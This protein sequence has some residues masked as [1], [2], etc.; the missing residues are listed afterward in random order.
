MSISKELEAEID[1][2]INDNREGSEAQEENV[3]VQEQGEAQEEAQ[4][5]VQ[6]ETQEEEA[7]EEIQEDTQKEI[8]EDT[9]A[10][11]E[12]EEDTP[13][14]TKG[15]TPEAFSDASLTRAVNAGLSLEEAR[16]FGSEKLLHNVSD[17]LEQQAMQYR[18]WARE[19]ETKYNQLQ[20]QQQQQQQQQEVVDP[21]A[22]LK[23]NPDDFDPDMVA[24]FDKL[25]EIVKNQHATIQD[26]QTYQ[27][28]TQAASYDQGRAEVEQW[29]DKEVSG[30]GEDFTDVMGTGDYNS[31]DRNSQQFANRDEIASQMSVLIAG[32]NAQ[33]LPAPN[34]SDVFQ[35]AS[36][37]VLAD[38][39]SQIE[40]E[41]LSGVLKNQSS[42]HIQR[43]NRT[44]VT[45]ALSAEEQDKEIAASIDQQFFG[46]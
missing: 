5:E 37:H 40:S 36:R 13:G 22:D 18:A 27:E 34:R 21:F 10:V 41:K 35:M 32:Y 8:Q 16:S 7:K 12:S 23:L 9:S 20:Q 17:R 14:D 33:G 19:E 29:F 11:V 44:K 2:A 24:K 4:E 1:T 25:T 42:Q 38:K 30:L 28:Q 6:E 39:Y 46:R 15:D 26:F 45:P 3:V 31:L 43:A